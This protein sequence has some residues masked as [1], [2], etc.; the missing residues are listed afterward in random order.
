MSLR[1][2]I[3]TLLT[4]PSGWPS[5]NDSSGTHAMYD[6]FELNWITCAEAEVADLRKR[7]RAPDCRLRGLFMTIHLTSVR[8]STEDNMLCVI[9]V[10]K[11]VVAKAPH[12]RNI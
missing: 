1:S 11:T 4:K 8:S 5:H 7:H 12:C 3:G 9:N 6:S 10:T 2:Q